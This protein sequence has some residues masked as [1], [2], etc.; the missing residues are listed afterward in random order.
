MKTKIQDWLPA[1]EVME[2][3]NAKE[4]FHVYVCGEWCIIKGACLLDYSGYIRF[5]ISGELCGANSMSV[6]PNDTI[7]VSY[8]V[9]KTQES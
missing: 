6:L 8:Y 1:Q 5:Y 2:R 4:R 3:V 7:E 9:N